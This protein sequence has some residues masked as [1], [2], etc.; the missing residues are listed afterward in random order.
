VP[1]TRYAG[2][3]GNVFQPSAGLQALVCERLWLKEALSA[4][5]QKKITGPAKREKS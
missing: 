1:L 2:L 5:F 3:F 4:S